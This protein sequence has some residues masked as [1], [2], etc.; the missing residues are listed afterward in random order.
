MKKTLNFEFVKEALENEQ[1]KGSEALTRYVNHIYEQCHEAER[2]VYNAPNETTLSIN[3]AVEATKKI[4]YDLK[5]RKDGDPEANNLTLK[6]L[7]PA[8]EPVLKKILYTHSYH[9]HKET[10]KDVQYVLDPW[11]MHANKLKHIDGYMEKTCYS[12]IHNCEILSDNVGSALHCLEECR[13]CIML[14]FIYLG[15]ISEFKPYVERSATDTE[16]LMQR[17]EGEKDVKEIV[18]QEAPAETVREEPAEE[19]IEEPAEKPIE[20]PA[21]EPQPQDEEK[22]TNTKK[23]AMILTCIAVVC[24]ALVFGI[25]K[26]NESNNQSSVEIARLS[27]Q[28]QSGFDNPV[29]DAAEESEPIPVA[30]LTQTE[31]SSGKPSAVLT[32]DG[33]MLSVDAKYI[34]DSASSLAIM[35][36]DTA[37]IK[38]VYYKIGTREMVKCD[39]L[40]ITGLSI[41]AEYNGTGFFSLQVC[42]VS[43]NG[44]SDWML[45][46][47]KLEDMNSVQ[48]I[49]NGT[50]LSTENTYFV[51][52]PMTLSLKTSG[53]NGRLFY[54]ID[55]GQAEELENGSSTIVVP[56]DY[57]GKQF[58]VSVWSGSGDPGSSIVNTYHFI[59]GD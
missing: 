52:I 15:F 44:Q 7:G 26:I 27:V 24:I 33:S 53:E 58:T 34:I 50:L 21:K 37:P 5:V 17:L 42:C 48:L 43:D 35:A 10:Q 38:N 45:Y 41:P 18:Q 22:H 40:N 13:N 59:S 14:I 16:Y 19:P 29:A 56:E 36:T 9:F 4:V 30:E 47:L 8:V 28:P 25:V 46:V 6:E 12:N 54:A 31:T 57:Q 1:V 20:E 49:T 3:S 2:T 11:R 23:L 51:D 55:G 39:G 32:V